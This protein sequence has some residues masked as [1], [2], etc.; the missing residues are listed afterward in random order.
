MY[1]PET[2]Y[3]ELVEN[4]SGVPEPGER[5]RKRRLFAVGWDVV[6]TVLAVANAVD[7]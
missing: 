5:P 6:D 2:G 1:S 4:R 3:V 7:R